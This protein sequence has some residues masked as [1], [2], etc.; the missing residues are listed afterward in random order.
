MEKYKQSFIQGTIILLA[1]GIVNRL[2]GF[3]PRIILPRV[4]GAEGVGLFQMGFP[5]LMLVLTLVTGGIPLAVAKLVAE[6]ESKRDSKRVVRI[7][8]LSVLF[9]LVLGVTV[10]LAC[11]AAIPALSRILFTDPR[12]G[13]PLLWMCPVI[14][15]AA[16]SSV[17]RGYFQGRQNMIPTAASQLMETITRI[18]G[19]LVF[20]FAM[21]PYGL[22]YA[23]GGAMVGMLAGEIAGLAVLLL[24]YRHYKSKQ[25][26]I[27][28]DFPSPPLAKPYGKT[29][30]DTTKSLLKRLIQVSV[31]VTASRLVG[32]FSYFIESVLI[33]QSLAL[34]GVATAVATMQYGALQGMVMPVLFLPGVLT[35]SL[36]V[37]L[38]PSLSE[39]N[40]KGD[41][42]TIHTRLHQSIKLALISGA[43]F[44]V[45]LY[46]LADP[47]CYY[48]Y[49]NSEIGVMLKMLAPA[50][51][52]QYCQG[53]LQASL[54]AL[55]QPG[56]ALLNTLIGSL[57]KL[58]LI[59]LLASKPEFG[60]LGAVLAISF[61]MMLVT[62]LHWN[63][64]TRLL[65]F[66]M[67][68]GD[69]LKICLLIPLTGAAC[70]WV[71]NHAP[72]EGAFTRFLLSLTAGTTV[73]VLGLP[74]LGLV[75][76]V[77][78][79]KLPFLNKR[80]PH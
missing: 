72:V 11:L 40:A 17:F 18:I 73:Y 65:R 34:A 12:V 68:S 44:A 53:P 59:F 5:F 43:P 23:A 61:N 78:L 35:Y 79:Q 10:T 21:L 63:S 74:L 24:Q 42:K 14:P 9:T 19:M 3:I 75:N 77:D 45:F 66:T 52:F 50:A 26:V 1:A 2:L 29:R 27:A 16:I 36:S 22:E 31:P 41:L 56:K 64:V 4:I 47:I 49:G 37:S 39:A 67:P 69:F 60:I 76:R 71:M 32:S 62:V 20:S 48:L 8:H 13:Y 57:I 55:N 25:P 15:I 6:A 46:V 38:V 70:M 33:V 30:P 7:L 58:S 28:G 54:Q 51:L 80:G